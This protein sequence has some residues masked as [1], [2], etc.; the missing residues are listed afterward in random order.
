MGERYG[1]AAESQ[2]FIEVRDMSAEALAGE[3]A[4]GGIDVLIG[5]VGKVRRVDESRKDYQGNEAHNQAD[6]EG[7]TLPYTFGTTVQVT[8]QLRTIGILAIAIGIV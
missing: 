5:I 8:S 1:Q 6:R 3:E 7:D 4:A 2:L